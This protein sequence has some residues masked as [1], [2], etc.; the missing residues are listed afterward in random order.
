MTVGKAKAKASE[1]KAA[2]EAKPVKDEELC[3][4]AAAGRAATDELIARHRRAVHKIIQG[5]NAPSQV[6]PEELEQ[7]GLLAL[8]QAI[9]KFRPEN[10]VKF[11]T[12]AWTVIRNDIGR[13]CG[14]ESDR[15]ASL[16]RA[17]VRDDGADFLVFIPEKSNAKEVEI[18]NGLFPA[19]P[20]VSRRVLRLRFGLDGPPLNWS[21]IGEQ[22]GLSIQQCQAAAETGLTLARELFE[23]ER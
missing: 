12:Y 23:R 20:L 9:K 19:M 13:A 7:V 4:I 15:F 2:P 6:D 5:C 8:Q 14:K 11:I 3:R 21:E 16:N 22:M 17:V 18:L 1:P 10:R